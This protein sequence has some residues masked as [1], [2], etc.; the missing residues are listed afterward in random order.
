MQKYKVLALG[1]TKQFAYL[2]SLDRS[3]TTL[4]PPWNKWLFLEA[5]SSWVDQYP[6]VHLLS[7]EQYLHWYFDASLVDSAEKKILD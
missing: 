7:L 6:N 2:I 4:H 1:Q 5:F 3:I